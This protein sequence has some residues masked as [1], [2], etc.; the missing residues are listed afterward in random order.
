MARALVTDRLWAQLEPLLPPEKAKPAG[1]RPRASD[2]ACLVGILF[3][4]KTGCAWNDLPA[5]LAPSGPTC[6]RRFR[7]WTAAGVWPRLWT[8][9]LRSL[10]KIEGIDLSRAVI[11]SAS[12]RAVFGG[13]TRVPTRRTGAKRA[14]NA[15]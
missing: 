9:L 5:E 14:V 13:L 8:Q 1:G 10:G 11:D 3:V 6:W 4:L 12:F 7:E 2:R 15:T